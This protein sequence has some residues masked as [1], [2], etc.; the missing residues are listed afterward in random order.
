MSDGSRFIHQKLPH[1]LMSMLAHSGNL[2]QETKVLLGTAFDHGGYIAGG[3]ATVLARWHLKIAHSDSRPRSLAESVRIHLDYPALNVKIFRC[4]DIDVWF[5]TERALSGFMADSRLRS[6]L[7]CKDVVSE[8]QTVSGCAVEYVVNNDARVQ[9][10]TKFLMPLEEQIQRFDIYNAAV[11]VTDD[12][13]VFP[14][15][16]E[17]LE[18]GRVLHVQRW[19]K[20]TSN[21]VFKY[22]TRKGYCHVTPATAQRILSKIDKCVAW[23]QKWSSQIALEDPRAQRLRETI[24]HDKLMQAVI[25]K[26]QKLQRL[27]YQFMENMTA[28]QLLHVSMLFNQPSRYDFAMQEIRRRMPLA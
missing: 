7:Q 24:T 23:D 22:I 4:S 1:S 2:K 3:F 21:R 11:A 20:W 28:E 6:L 17:Q 5:P 27:L 15:H 8:A 9:V 14:E 19:N 16:W 10:I 26:P 18:R 25:F 12:A 13:I